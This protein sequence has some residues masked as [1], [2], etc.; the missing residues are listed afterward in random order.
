MIKSSQSPGVR[1]KSSQQV[2]VSILINELF[3]DSIARTYFAKFQFNSPPPPP[4]KKKEEVPI[5][6]NEMNFDTPKWLKNPF[7]LLE[8]SWILSPKVRMDCECRAD[9]P[10]VPERPYFF[11]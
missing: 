1:K 11:S 3:D 5:I 4:P 8:A 2:H 6:M 10:P 7:C 9:L